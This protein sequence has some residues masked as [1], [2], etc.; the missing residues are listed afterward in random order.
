[1][2][3]KNEAVSEF[4]KSKTI[5]EQREYL[6]VFTVKDELMTVIRD[7]KIVIIVGET[8]SGKTTQLT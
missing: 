1:L 3:K 2:K 7:N 5:K 8:G 6:P 4:A